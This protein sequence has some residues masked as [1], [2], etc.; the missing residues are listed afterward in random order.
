ML[1][2]SVIRDCSFLIFPEYIISDKEEKEVA[3]KATNKKADE[4]YIR[5]LRLQSHT[6]LAFISCFIIQ[7]NIKKIYKCFKIEIFLVNQLAK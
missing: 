4:F 5:S 6:G 2:V 3:L 1:L 7:F